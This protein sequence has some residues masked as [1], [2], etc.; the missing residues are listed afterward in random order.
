[1]IMEVLEFE[2][3]NLL[4]LNKKALNKIRGMKIGM[5]FQEPMTS[6]NPCYTVGSQLFEV[7]KIHETSTTKPK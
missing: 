2:K 7:L 1:M 6:L 3:Q 4:S 5:I